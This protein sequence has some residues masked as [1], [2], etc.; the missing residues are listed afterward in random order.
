MRAGRSIAAALCLV[1]AALF[2]PAAQAAYDPLAGGT[3]TLTLEKGF[4]SYLKQ[5]G[6]ELTATA[7]AKR[8]GAKLTMPVG[9]G[10]LDPTTGRGTIEVE[11]T[12]AFQGGGKRVP[13]RD[14]V[15]KAKRTPLYAK[16]GGGQLKIATARRVSFQR[17]GF[18][19]VFTA[20][21]LKLTAK[22]ATRLNKKLRPERPFLAGQ[23]IGSLKSRAQPQTV[24]VLPGGRVTLTP[25]PEFL[26]K[27]K[28]LFVSLNPV[29]PAELAPG[30]TFSFPIVAGGQIAPDASS[31]TLRSGGDLELL[32]LGGGQI[33]WHEFWVDLGLGV[34]SAEANVQ[35]S[36]P[37]AGK[38]GRVGIFDLDRAAA[39][40]SSDPSARRVSVSVAPLTLQA[41]TAAS[42]NQA[43]A[44]GEEVFR[45]GEAFGTVS[46]TAQ[47]Q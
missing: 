1:G 23:A 38:Q 5:A 27:L 35:P 24:S 21:E 39:L 42:M 29:S 4:A 7:P 12:L 22:V 9:S 26:A 25:T 10:E 43:F 15:V 19:G 34:D 20:T 31:G 3:A 6:I 11:G 46:F 16:V 14:I 30:P 17:D 45:A 44:A 32:Q 47:G 8:R 28:A 37:Y 36:P 18:G 41:A 40:V 33:F 2:A 13:L